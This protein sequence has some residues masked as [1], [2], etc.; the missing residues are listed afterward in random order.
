MYLTWGEPPEAVAE[1]LERVSER[2]NALGR[3]LRFG[4]RPH[5]IARDTSAEAW[6]EAHWNGCTSLVAEWSFSACR[7]PSLVGSRCLRRGAERAAA[8][9]LR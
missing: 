1:K 3:E 2:A 6:A 8:A 4:I 7:R 9:T 5:V